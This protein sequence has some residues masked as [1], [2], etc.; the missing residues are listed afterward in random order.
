MTDPLPL[1]QVQGLLPPRASLVGRIG[2]IAAARAALLDEAVPLLTLT[3]PGGVGKTRLALAVAHEV[4][5]SFADGAVVVE[6]AQLSDPALVPSTLAAAL[7]VQLDVADTSIAAIVATL[8]GQQRLLVLDNCDHVLAAT[9]EL[10]AAL[11]AGCPAVQILVTSRSPFHVRGE[12]VLPVAPLPLP[13]IDGLPSLKELARN[14]A[15][16]LFVERARQVDP[17]L[18]FEEG[19]AATIAEICCQ[20][21]GLPLAIE[22]A[23][24][25]VAHL[26]PQAILERLAQR[27][28]LLTGGPRDAPVRQQTLRDTIAW[29]YELLTEEEQRLFRW[30]SVFV[31]GFN[32]DA[33]EAIAAASDLG[34]ELLG[35]IVVLIDHSL[36]RK[37]TEPD[38]RARYTMLET[39]REFGLEQLS[40]RGETEAARSG[41]ARYIHGLVTQVEPSL[42]EH[43]M[44]LRWLG[45]L[46]GERGNLQV[47]LTWWLQRGEAEPALATASALVAYWW[48]RS[49]F[50]AGRSWCERVLAL[51]VDVAYA[52]SQISSLYGTCV[53]ASN[54]GDHE[55]ALAAGEAMLQL[56]RTHADP[57]GAIRAHY[58][59]C[60]AARRKGDNERAMSHALAA[61]AHTREAVAQDAISPVWLAWTLS[62]MGEGPDIV[63][64]DRAEEAAEEA[65][66][67]FKAG[68]SAWGMA[69]ALQLLGAYALNR[70]DLS[71]AAQCLAESV[72][73]RT[74]I[75]ERFGAVEG[76]IAAASIATRS[77]Q[78]RDAA[79]LLGAANAWA[80]ELGY[81]PHGRPYL[82]HGRTVSLIRENLGDP[83]FTAVSAVG[84]GMTWTDALCEA[85]RML[86]DL[87]MQPDSVDVGDKSE[88][89]EPERSHR[90]ARRALASSGAK[91]GDG[92]T[93]ADR[94]STAGLVETGPDLTRREQQ[95]LVLIG[96]HL[97]DAE[98]ADQLFI[99]VRTVE[100]HL[101]NILGK[102][103]A[104]NRREAVSIASRLGL[105]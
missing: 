73:L 3:G 22:L 58:A 93:V 97:S 102:L 43:A 18:P 88:Q 60:H 81:E 5:G 62:F 21:D 54:E 78:F 92:R 16:R 94:P 38:G 44:A 70:G 26:P 84:A 15:V 57:I 29:S 30:L 104:E 28:T 89:R 7:D 90:A 65:L 67:L 95:V 87:A 25:R 27:L 46:D 1:D 51:A 4:V 53:L 91:P 79:R 45:R 64:S 101:G 8:H 42:M 100:F 9:A 76:L 34:G 80:S 50:A 32:L 49:D 24:A 37:Q 72:S 66:A 17:V 41:H 12:H 19:S 82:D 99:G 74:A 77:G 52:G 103:G 6:L 85:Q 40:A 14:D 47:A 10:A 63:G 71:R 98:I 59:L 56:A 2:E 55:R 35:R 23:A 69:N 36:L 39:I 86:T 31:G 48:F 96:Q 20:L 33:A 68:G 75:G 105:I 83:C 61:V 11:L 13:P